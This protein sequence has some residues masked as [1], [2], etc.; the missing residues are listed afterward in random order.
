[1]TIYDTKAPHMTSLW[2]IELGNRAAIYMLWIPGWTD[3][4][5]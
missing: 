2:D 5:T 4:T 1:M 3:K